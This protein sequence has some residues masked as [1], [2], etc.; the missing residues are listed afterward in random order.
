MWRWLSCL[1]H[2]G[3][4]GAKCA[5]MLVASGTGAMALL[6]SF[7]SL[8]QLA[9]KRPLWLVLLCCLV[10]QALKG[11]H[12]LGSFSIALASDTHRVTLSGVF[13]YW[14]V[15]STSVWGERSYSDGSSPCT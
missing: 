2:R 11:L 1:D 3:L 15:A 9:F 8:W 13:L 10:Q 14:S 4:G 7:S 6:Q 5:E 12:W